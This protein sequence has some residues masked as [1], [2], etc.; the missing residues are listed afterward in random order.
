[1]KLSKVKFA[2]SNHLDTIFTEKIVWEKVKGELVFTFV[3]LAHFPVKCENKPEY[4]LVVVRLPTNNFLIVWD[5][6]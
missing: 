3:F 5:R 6:D 2:L 1:M 4:L